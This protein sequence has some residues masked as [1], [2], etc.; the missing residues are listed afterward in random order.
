MGADDQ[1]V[2]FPVNLNIGSPLLRVIARKSY[3]TY[4]T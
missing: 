3:P 1:L 4:I 2:G